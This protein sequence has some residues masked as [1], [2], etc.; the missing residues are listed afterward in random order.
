MAD[1]TITLNQNAAECIHS[2]SNIGNTVYQNICSG[3][4]ATVPWGVADWISAAFIGALMAMAACA[5]VV[6]C[7]AVIGVSLDR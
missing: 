2:I 5:I 7:I 6:E 4:S 1:Q 3:A